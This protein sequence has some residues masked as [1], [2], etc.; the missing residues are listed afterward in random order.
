M[1]L[2]F[3]HSLMLVIVGLHLICLTSA[4][5]IGNFTLCMVIWSFCF[6]S[7]TLG[8]WRAVPEPN[9]SLI[10]FWYL[11]LTLQKTAIYP[12]KN[13][14][15]IAEPNAN[16]MLVLLCLNSSWYD[17]IEIQSG[18]STKYQWARIA[19]CIAASTHLITS[20]NSNW[21]WCAMSLPFVCIRCHIIFF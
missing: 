17:F 20:M 3:M 11:E 5:W 16:L 19:D 21:Q 2:N 1:E 13:L 4:E 9:V 18:H 7:L 10:I 15:P 8:I 6:L 12:I 14:L